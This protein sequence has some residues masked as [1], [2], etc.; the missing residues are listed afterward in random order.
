MKPLNGCRV[1]VVEDQ[2]IIALSITD[3]LN[4][5][6]AIIVGP[7]ATVEGAL[8]LVESDPP[9]VALLDLW[10]G[11]EQVYPVC[12]ALTASGIPFALSSGSDVFAEGGKF[13]TA[14]RIY[15]PFHPDEL[16]AVLASL[17]CS[18]RCT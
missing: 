3:I 12:D 9:D 2:P 16:A 10:L 15:K 4:G 8:R 7:S 18:N 11:K 17:C 14:P 5:L 6:G 1:L 13:R